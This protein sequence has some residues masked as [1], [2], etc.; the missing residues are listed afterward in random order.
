[1]R[2]YVVNMNYINKIENTEI[3]LQNLSSVPV[4][5]GKSKEIKECYLAFQMDRN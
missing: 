2:S 3:T 1:H 5:Q 4:A